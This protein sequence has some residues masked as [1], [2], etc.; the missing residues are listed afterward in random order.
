MIS[1][2]EE[3]RAKSVINLAN[4][5][6]RLLLS[7]AQLLAERDAD[8]VSGV[9]RDLQNNIEATNNYYATEDATIAYVKEHG[10]DEG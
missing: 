8:Y 2:Y 6:Q 1:A 5:R 9:R 7:D 4:W 3:G 10:T